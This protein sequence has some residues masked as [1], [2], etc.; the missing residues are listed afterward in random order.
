MNHE[1]GFDEST[2][3]WYEDVDKKVKVKKKVKVAVGIDTPFPNEATSTKELY[4]IAKALDSFHW[5]DLEIN[6]WAL[7]ESLRLKL[8]TPTQIEIIVSLAEQ[9]KSWNVCFCHISSFPCHEK[10]AY[11]FLKQMQPWQLRVC[12]NDNGDLKLKLNPFLVW[13][14][15]AFRREKHIKEWYTFGGSSEETNT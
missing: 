15:D 8:L 4:E 6:H 3:E 1:V 9:V 7:V 2:G 11:K 5:R 12:S 10:S 14:G 13:K